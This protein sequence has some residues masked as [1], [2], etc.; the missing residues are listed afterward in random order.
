M[1]LW[2]VS[3]HSQRACSGASGLLSEG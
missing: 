3:I 1:Q 2:R